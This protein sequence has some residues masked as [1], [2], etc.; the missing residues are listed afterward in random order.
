[1]KIEKKEKI[2][3]LVE[4]IRLTEALRKPTGETVYRTKTQFY[5]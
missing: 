5:L 4:K 1:M 2:K 3:F